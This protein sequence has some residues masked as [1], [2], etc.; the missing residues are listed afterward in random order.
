VTVVAAG[1]RC[2]SRRWPGL[3]RYR[4]SGVHR[5]S[6]ARPTADWRS[7]SSESTFGVP[8]RHS[9]DRDDAETST[10]RRVESRACQA[11]TVPGFTR[12]SPRASRTRCARA[13]PKA[14]G[15]ESAESVAASSAAAQAGTRREEPVKSRVAKLARFLIQ[16]PKLAKASQPRF[17]LRSGAHLRQS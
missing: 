2:T 17:L 3:R 4:A 12:R 11:T 16:G 10:A 6:A 15:R 14:L 7:T 1:A 8:P 13:R 5:E 9:G